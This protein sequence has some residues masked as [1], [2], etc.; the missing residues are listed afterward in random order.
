M[1]KHNPYEAPTS[2]AGA[3]VPSM[4]TNAEYGG[5]EYEISGT[6]PLPRVC[7][8]CAATDDVIKRPERLVVRRRWLQFAIGAFSML[9]VLSFGAFRVFTTNRVWFGAAL[10]FVGIAN[11]ATQRRV[12]LALPLCVACDEAW[13]RARNALYLAAA[14]S[15][16]GVAGATI[17]VREYHRYLSWS[18]GGM[19]P[20]VGLLPAIGLASWAN[21]RLLAAKD[22]I[23]DRV[24]LTGVSWMAIDKIRKHDEPLNRH[25]R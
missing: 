11:R 13:S 8:K 3:R 7:L 10:L 6:A 15:L 5:V 1:T 12:D 24:R 20:F 2:V 14:L 22:I 25:A 17:L 16:V 21:K 9:A 19:L 23:G 18:M 4:G